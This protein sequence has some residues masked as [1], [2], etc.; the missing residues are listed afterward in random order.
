MKPW[1]VTTTLIG[2]PNNKTGITDYFNIN[3]TRET[4]PTLMWVCGLIIGRK[5][6]K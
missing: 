3:G 2:K 4:L 1:G 6:P 5:D